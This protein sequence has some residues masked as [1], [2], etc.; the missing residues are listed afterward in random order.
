[1]FVRYS[2]E[3]IACACIFL[4]A[5]TVQPQVPL[6]DKP[7]NWYELFDASDTDVNAIA[8]MLLNLYTN[9]KAVSWREMDEKIEKLRSKIEATQK[10]AK[11]QLVAQKITNEKKKLEEDSDRDDARKRRAKSRSRSRSKSR[12]RSPKRKYSPGRRR[13]DSPDRNSRNKIRSGKGGRDDR[14]DRDRRD[15]RREEKRRRSRSRSKSRERYSDRDRDR[16]KERSKVREREVYQ[17]LGKRVRPRS[18][19]PPAR[20][21]NDM[22]DENTPLEEGVDQLTQWRERCSEHAAAFKA[23]LD[24]CNE[25]VNSRTNTE[26]TCHQ[27]MSDFIHHL[28]QCAMPKAFA[29]LK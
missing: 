18:P 24:E 15:D 28:D 2:P 10:A 7:R 1:M 16:V 22:P 21:R 13:R 9:Q 29:A 14:R 11:A 8:L 27:E 23:V 6:P 25:R 3:T 4:A 26:E 20:F 17:S 5:R 19:T 12:S